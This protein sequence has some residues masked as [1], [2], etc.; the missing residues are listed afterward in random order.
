V[1]LELYDLRAKV[2]PES[3]CAL[4]AFARAHDVDKSELVREILHKW[5]LRQMH[6][7]TLLA[8]CLKAKGVEVESQGTSGKALDWSDE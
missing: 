2:T 8:S 7:A 3:H 6:G 5:A 1:S 4:A